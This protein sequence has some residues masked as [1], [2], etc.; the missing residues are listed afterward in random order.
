MISCRF[1]Q[2]PA[3][4]PIRLV[5]GGIPSAGRLEVFY[6]GEYGTVCDDYFGMENAKVAC[7]QLGYAG[8]KMLAPEAHF[9]E[10]TGRIMLDNVRC[11]GTEENLAQ[12]SHKEWTVHDCNH[13]EDVGIMCFKGMVR[14]RGTYLSRFLSSCKSFQVLPVFT[15]F[16]SDTVKCPYLI[17]SLQG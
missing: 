1:L 6:D 2:G 4:V 9:G 14:S 5:N 3:E 13:R 12:C 8:V 16:P 15:F 17:N 7:R 11:V 10:G